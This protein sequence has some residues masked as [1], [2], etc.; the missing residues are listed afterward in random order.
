M[1]SRHYVEPARSYVSSLV[2]LVVL[3]A[4]FLFDLLVLGGG[5]VH[6]LAWAIAI[7]IVVGF[8]ALIVYAAR[9]LR[10]IRV[11]DDEVRVGEESLP[12]KDILGVRPGD[13]G[14]VLG[15]RPGEGLSRG[16]VGLTLQ[17]TGD[18]TMVLATRDPQRLAE[19]LGAEDIAP[20]IRRALP[21]DL[22]HLPE[23]D[24][25][26]D[27]LFRVAGLHLPDIPY[28]VDAL[29]DSQ[30]VF[31]A[32]RPP[33]AFVQ[34][35]EV[36]GVAHV[37]ELAVLPSHMRQGLGSSLLETACA[38]ARSAG[39]PAITLTTYAEVAWNAPFYASRGFV[40]LT[41]LTPELA[42]LRD[43]ERDIGLDEVGR[44][45]AMRKELPA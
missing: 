32:G 18:R 25:R 3:V 44:R 35:D 33:V 13:E 38:W 36:D 27:S 45:I 15:R 4:G 39:Y 9:S 41:E 6:A 10:S 2:L 19:V 34:I 40:E 28:P 16:T 12:R 24:R 23:I 1:T 31:V 29:H 21:A 20:E 11:T 43:W 37:Q 30:A 17:L 26:A 8:D 42:E 14:P 7:V 22:E 5:R